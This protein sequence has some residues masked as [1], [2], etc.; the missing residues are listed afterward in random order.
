MSLPAHRVCHR[1]ERLGRG[2]DTLIATDRTRCQG[3]LQQLV[4]WIDAIGGRP[5]PVIQVER[6][7][8]M[9]DIIPLYTDM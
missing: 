7:R 4:Q 8:A 9:T 1:A 2:I 3:F 6:D 5:S